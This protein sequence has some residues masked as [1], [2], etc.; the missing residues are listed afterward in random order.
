MGF[1]AL[2]KR[3][4]EM[5]KCC[6]AEMRRDLAAGTGKKIYTAYIAVIETYLIPFF[7]WHSPNFV[8]TLH[9]AI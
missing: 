8:D 2:V 4:D 6:V 5:A 3:F 1:T 9:N 7:G